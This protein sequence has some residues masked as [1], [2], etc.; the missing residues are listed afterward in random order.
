MTTRPPT[1]SDA[2]PAG[3]VLRE[4]TRRR[5][6]DVQRLPDAVAEEVP[7]ALLYNGQPHA[8]MMATAQDLEDF[9]LG[10]SLTEGIIATPAQ[11]LG[12]ERHDVLTG[13]ELHVRIEDAPAAALGERTRMLTGRTGCGLCGTQTLEAAVRQPAV[14]V[15]EIVIKAAA[16]QR[17]LR[18]MPV[19]QVINQVTGATHAAAWAS[20][21]GQLRLL[22]EDVGRH[23]ALDKLIGAMSRA[24]IAPDSG[25]ALVS[26]RASYEMVMKAAAAGIGLLAAVSAPTALAIS[27][28]NSTGVTL[29]G[30]ARRD[31]YAIYSHPLRMRD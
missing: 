31:G 30:F 13:V 16:L 8:V 6:D 25:F 21:D 1:P 9:A 15:N 18:E 17:A 29:I 12:I 23:N 27:L 10:F 26:S 4:V 3:A 11:C 5:G 7:I 2:L 24:S 20:S 14:V 19:I 28:A 22:R